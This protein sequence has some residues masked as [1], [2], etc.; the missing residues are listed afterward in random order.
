MFDTEKSYSGESNDSVIAI[1]DR[2]TLL[3][4]NTIECR[5]NI[6]KMNE[7]SIVLV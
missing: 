2:K 3:E 6:N 1:C 5:P 7:L 4:F